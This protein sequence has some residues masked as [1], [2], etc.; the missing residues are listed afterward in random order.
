LGSTEKRAVLFYRRE[1][2]S[3]I[4]LL[5]VGNSHPR[6]LVVPYDDPAEIAAVI[7]EQT[8]RSESLRS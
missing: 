5:I 2:A 6:C 7:A 4:S 1:L 3:R 8:K